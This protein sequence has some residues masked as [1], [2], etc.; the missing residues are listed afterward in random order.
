MKC[1]L[2]SFNLCKYQHIWT[3]ATLSCL[4]LNI[5]DDIQNG[6][7]N[8]K[9]GFSVIYHKFD[10]EKHQ[11]F[12]LMYLFLTFASLVVSKITNRICMLVFNSFFSIK[13]HISM[14]QKFLCLPKALHPLVTVSPLP[15]RTNLACILIFVLCGASSCCHPMSTDQISVIHPC[16]N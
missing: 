9:N 10:H 12:W 1:A 11:Y 8:N 7:Q 15:K 5:K 2:C 13:M 3:E 16:A 4:D 14:N 6:C